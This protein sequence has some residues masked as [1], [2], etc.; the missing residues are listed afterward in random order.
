MIPKFN[1]HTHTVLCDGKNSAE[2]MVLAAIEC[3]CDGI[4]FSGHSFL[5]IGKQDDGEWFMSEAGMLEYKDEI[6]GLK[7]KYKDKIEILLGIEYDSHSNIDISPYD[8]VIGS[9]HYNL[10]NGKYIPIDLGVNELKDYVK[11][12]YRD[13]Y[14][15]C[16]DYY[17]ALAEIKQKTDCDIVGHFDLVAKFNEDG[18]LFDENDPRYRCAALECLNRLAAENVIFEIN[19]GAISRGY[20]KLPYPSRNILKEMVKLGCK[21]TVTTDCHSGEALLCCY[22]DAIRY[23]RECGAK[24]LYFYKN[25][26]FV[27]YSL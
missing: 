22:D 21:L 10:K 2:E 3:G 7:E 26:G 16:E 5:N 19:T 20:K 24:E 1:L 6:T 9:V 23:A 18:S 13:I 8:Y 4:G 25:G 15:F 12:Y 17:K 14:E 11:K 27:P